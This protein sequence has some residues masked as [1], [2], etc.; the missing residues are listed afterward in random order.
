MPGSDVANAANFG[1]CYQAAADRTSLLYRAQLIDAVLGS[2]S[3]GTNCPYG[4][5]ENTASAGRLYGLQATTGRASF[6]ALTSFGDSAYPGSVATPLTEIAQCCSESESNYPDESDG[7]YVVIDD[8]WYSLN[9]SLGSLDAGEAVGITVGPGLR[10]LHRVS[11]GFLVIG[12]T[13]GGVPAI[14]RRSSG[15]VYSSAT[16]TNSPVESPDNVQCIAKTGDGELL[17][18]LQSTTGDVLYSA[19][20]GAN[21]TYYSHDMGGVCQA[22]SYDAE[23]GLWVAIRADTGTVYTTDDPTSG[24]W[25]P[26]SATAASPRD[27]L[28]YGPM[29]IVVSSSGTV[30]YYFRAGNDWTGLHGSGLLSINALVPIASRLALIGTSS[31]IT[32]VM[33]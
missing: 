22:V 26:E 2:K 27:M 7:A 24:T 16:I 31:Y 19:D 5:I 28:C 10:L 32:G 21:W 33:L 18:V 9:D 3:V 6:R 29:R 1:E 14:R 17:A 13:S 25:T 15:G 11:S 30:Q 23:H 20:D 12:G 8:T 4:L